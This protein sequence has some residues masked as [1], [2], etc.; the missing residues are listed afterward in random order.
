[1]LSLPYTA[2]EMGWSA[3]ALMIFLL[4]V[5][6]YS[7]VLLANSINAVSSLR[8]QRRQERTFQP[9]SEANANNGD[10]NCLI[11]YTVL[12]KEA[13]GRNG[14][15]FVLSIL[16]TELF[17]ALVSFYINIGINV[18]VIFSG[19]INFS[20]Y[21][22]LKLDNL[23]FPLGFKGVSIGFAILLSGAIVSFMSFMDMKTISR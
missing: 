18:N 22:W 5:F 23:S 16:G 7:Y 15:K 11:D 2:A 3:I 6:L 10:D 9:L 1:M 19:E 4:V 21:L 17:L 20:S 13:F 12:G 8:E 14:D